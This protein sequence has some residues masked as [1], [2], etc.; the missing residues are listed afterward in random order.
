MDF[1]KSAEGVYVKASTLGS[2]EA[3]L[4]FL[5]D[6]KIPVFQWGIGEV[7]K[8]DVKKAS[9]MKEKKLKEYALILCFDVPVNRE[10]QAL[11]DK[12]GIPIYTADIIYHLFDQFTSYMDRIKAEK[13]TEAKAE[14][15]FPVILRMD[16]Q[17]IFHKNN[18]LIFGCDIK[19]GQLRIGTPLCLP[20]KDFLE[21]GRVESIERDKKQVQIAKKGQKVCVKIQQSTAQQ[22]IHYGRHFDYTSE[23]FSKVTRSSI[24]SLKTTFRDE[25]SKGDWELLV[26]MKAVFKI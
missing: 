8:M 24:D 18:P 14:A 26:G 16:K 11:A 19:D 3:L 1:E 23:L 21:I 2:L 5:T 22:H 10:A 15:V 9:I 17:Y 7:Q 13:K 25:M 20:D 12:E 4:A 6:M